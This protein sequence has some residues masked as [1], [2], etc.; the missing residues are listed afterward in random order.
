MK[1]KSLLFVLATSLLAL[2]SCGPTKP[3]DSSTTQGESTSS[4]VSIPD[5]PVSTDTSNK[6]SSDSS[7]TSSNSS[8]TSTPDVEPAELKTIAE[9]LEL[10]PANGDKSEKRYRVKATV[11]TV[12]DSYHGEMRIK[13]ETG[14][15][16]VYGTFDK[17]GA[18]LYGELPEEKRPFAGDEI[19]LECNVQNFK[20]KTLQ[21][22]D[23]W[24]LSFTHKD[25]VVDLSQYKDATVAQARAAEEGAKLHMKDLQV[26]SILLGQKNKQQGVLVSDGA[27][28]IY[29][30]STDI[31]GRA[32]VGDKFEI[33][34][35]KT[36]YI[37]EKEQANAAKYGYNGCNQIQNV[38]ILKKTAGDGS[39][40]LKFAQEKTVKEIF[41]TPITE[42]IS[43]KVFKTNA[44][45]TKEVVEGKN[46]YT[47]YYINDLD[48]TTGN[49]VYTQ[50]SGADFAW[51]DPFVN[52]ICTVYMT[53]L[54]AKST[55]YGCSWRFVPVKIEDNK[56]T[57]DK[58]NAAQFAIDYYAFDQFETT[59]VADPA[60]EM[61]TSVSST[62][63]DFEGVRLTYSSDNTA[64]A[65]FAVKDGKT[66]FHT[67]G[68]GTA[69]IKITAT[70]DQFESATK[71]IAIERKAA[72]EIATIDVSVAQKAAIGT[73]VT[74][75]GIIG[76]SLSVQDGFY[77]FGEN[78]MI[79]V[80]LHDSAKWFAHVKMG[81]KIILKATRDLWTGEGL[82]YGQQCLTD[83]K[84]VYNEYGNH[85]LPDSAFIK[86]KT[87]A[88]LAK[89]TKNLKD[90]SV[91]MNAYRVY[92]KVTKS[93]GSYPTYSVSDGDSKIQVYSSSTDQYAF[94][95]PFIDKMTELEVTLC[96]W[97]GK[98]LKLTVLSAKYYNTL[99]FQK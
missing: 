83:A 46:G 69:N 66:I 50:N 9:V 52:K 94:L 64:V 44:Y 98:Q 59:Y 31:A 77:L 36:S 74:V 71:T 41:E 27:D 86:G 82:T 78:G 61:V 60:L 62:L 80:T 73:E 40:D 6:T 97:N 22:V 35:E 21:L 10:A 75:E 49:Y 18:I 93:S 2:A 14:E 25:P 39:I 45:I 20:K 91:T 65:S 54:N 19:E 47:N 5:T 17:T 57:F 8:S 88:D 15:A 63:L 51:I 33:V 53:A 90:D 85:P 79:A 72:D 30:F 67:N 3:N 37:L 48:G 26:L 89:L 38:T 56:F 76:P 16:Y 12:M 87:I 70:L 68:V 34:G 42:D 4:P 11:V 32:K 1:N 84:L 43:T 28:S 29:V 24:I 96:N 81:Q 55:A 99:H 23:A 92:G 13:D 95:E 58:N 7:N